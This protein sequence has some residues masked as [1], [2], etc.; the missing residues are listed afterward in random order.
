MEDPAATLGRTQA[1]L[2]KA[3]THPLR[4]TILARLD[5]QALSPKELAAQ[6]GAPLSVVSYHVKELARLGFVELVHT[7]QRRG[8][9]QHWYKSKERQPLGQRI[10]AED[11]HVSRESFELDERGWTELS[12]L[13]ARTLERIDTLRG[14]AQ[15]RLAGDREDALHATVSL[16]LFEGPAG[17]APAVDGR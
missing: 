10:R 3:F 8:A 5:E 4:I 1:R 7:E 16:M 6:L 2:I 13:L 14:E 11:V 15:Q 17:A 12:E 9:I